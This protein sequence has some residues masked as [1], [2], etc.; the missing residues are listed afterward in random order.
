ML[1]RGTPRELAPAGTPEVV[2]AFVPPGAVTGH[3]V[4]VSAHKGPDAG[5]RVCVMSERHP[6]HY[7]RTRH[8]Y[9]YAWRASAA[10]LASRHHYVAGGA[11]ECPDGALVRRL[12]LPLY[13]HDC[14][15][16]KGSKAII[17]NMMILSIF[18]LKGWV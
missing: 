8:V 6:A 12:R 4:R 14:L 2:P 1:L 15:L 5:E 17:H 10:D 11:H 13:F 7:G 9:V 3:L 18:A 16:L